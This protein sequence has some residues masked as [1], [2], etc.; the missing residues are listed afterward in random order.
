M[1][2]FYK[3]TNYIAIIKQGDIVLNCKDCK[4]YTEALIYV[5]ETMK[6]LNNTG[7]WYIHKISKTFRDNPHKT[8]NLKESAKEKIDKEFWNEFILKDIKNGKK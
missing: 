3:S 5:E 2:K 6:S 1:V 8:K 7:K 4:T